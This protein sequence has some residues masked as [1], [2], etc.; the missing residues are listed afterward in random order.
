M[1]TVRK[2]YD[3]LTELAPLN[4]ALDDDNVGLLIGRDGTEVS[5]I[6]IALD[7]TA[8]VVTA[9]KKSGANLLI[10]HHPFVRTNIRPAV[11]NGT[12]HMQ[13]QQE[14]MLN[15]IENKMSLISMHTNLDAV[16]GGVND[17]LAS[18]LGITGAV[19]FEPE[20]IGRVGFLRQTL[21]LSDFAS[22]SKTLLGSGVVKYHDAGRAVKHVAVGGG[23][24][25][26]YLEYAKNVGFDTFVTSDVKHH[27]FILAKQLGVNLL[28]CG[29][30]AT[31]N[32][33]MAVVYEYLA[34]NFPEVN[35][36]LYDNE[37]PFKCL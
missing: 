20:G 31:E 23:S 36:V 10:S 18:L 35:I 29:H 17:V 19:S 9:A 5:G 26:D 16:T 13:P 6:Y 33:A 4:L 30:Y 28:D 22:R 8:E 27:Q 32:P 7:I 1:I 12:S 37:E 3:S 34:N 24:C 15:I 21:E 11:L 25:G 14:L 2:I